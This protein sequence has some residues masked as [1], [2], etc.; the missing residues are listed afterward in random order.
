MV[1]H[2]CQ[3]PVFLQRTHGS[4]ANIIIT[5]VLPCFDSR[6]SSSP[7]FFHVLTRASHLFFHVLTRAS[8]PHLILT[9]DDVKSLQAD[10]DDSYLSDPGQ[11]RV[12]AQ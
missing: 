11:R 10:D 5:S 3:E 6:I 4:E 7:L 12:N 2:L 1:Q 8:Q 9:S